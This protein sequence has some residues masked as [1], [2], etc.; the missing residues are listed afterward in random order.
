MPQIPVITVRLTDG[1]IKSVSRDDIIL[2]NQ[3]AVVAPIQ[4]PAAPKS[5]TINSPVALDELT[6]FFTTKKINISEIVSVVKGIS[7]SAT[8]T[9]RFGV[10][11]SSTGAEV[12]I[13]GIISSN[14]T[15]GLVTTIFN[16]P[17]IPQDN[18]V[19]VVINT[20]SGT[21]DQLH[22]SMDFN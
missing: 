11:R 6:V 19:W 21:V 14:T 9:I 20:V 17:I 5:L 4:G 16:N 8:F 7:P 15:T 13:G 22:V 3:D 12:V 2:R 18:F 10:D 1:L